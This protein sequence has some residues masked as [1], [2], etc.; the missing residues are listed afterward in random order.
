MNRVIRTFLRWGAGAALVVALLA[1]VSMASTAVSVRY[2]RAHP[3]QASCWARIAWY[4]WPSDGNRERLAVRLFYAGDEAA[5]RE[6]IQRLWGA[7]NKLSMPGY[8][9]LMRHLDD[10]RQDETLDRVRAEAL[11]QY[12]QSPSVWYAAGTVS[13]KRGDSQEAAVQFD[14]AADLAIA[15]R[16]APSTARNLLISQCR[17][18]VQ[19]KEFETA[20][21]AA[22]RA[23]SVLPDEVEIHECSAISLEAL[24]RY[25]EAFCAWLRAS[26]FPQHSLGDFYQ[27]CMCLRRLHREDEATKLLQAKASALDWPSHSM[28]MAAIECQRNPAAARKALQSVSSLDPNITTPKLLAAASYAWQGDCASALKGLKQFAPLTYSDRFY[29]ALYVY[30]CSPKV[31]QR[32]MRENL[33][34]PDEPGKAAENIFRYLDLRDV[35]EGRT[36]LMPRGIIFARDKAR[37]SGIPA[38]S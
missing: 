12:P 28:L 3:A 25:D 34:P 26:E 4:T 11:K 8:M 36:L 5:G 10:S 21:A 2:G 38:A 18:H 29:R 30:Q 14:K 31:A 7:G 1:G 24:G 27:A 32:K 13:W 22:Q 37:G 15:Q 19:N 20:I 17:S 35:L 16:L 23:L 6:M 33:L 9:V